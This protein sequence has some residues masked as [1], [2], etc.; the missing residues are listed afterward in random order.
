MNVPPKYHDGLTRLRIMFD[1]ICPAI[2][3]TNKIEMR[4]LYW[5]PFRPKSLSSE[6]SLALTRAFRSRKL[7]L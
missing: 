5:V 7:K 1:G 4:V 6:L 3:P 2:Y